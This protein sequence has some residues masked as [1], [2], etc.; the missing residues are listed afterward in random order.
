MIVFQAY[1]NKHTEF[2]VLYNDEYFELTPQSI[3]SIERLNEICILSEIEESICL[4]FFKKADVN[5]LYI[6]SPG[7]SQYIVEVLP[8]L[9]DRVLELP[10]KINSAGDVTEDLKESEINIVLR[11]IFTLKPKQVIL[12][13]CNSINNPE[14]EK[15]LSNL[16]KGAGYRVQ[17]SSDTTRLEVPGI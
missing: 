8:E 10:G 15:S 4:P 2:E 9:A 11:K 1:N 17:L 13:L 7:A 3:I 6:S 14:H 12:C 16:I 5:M